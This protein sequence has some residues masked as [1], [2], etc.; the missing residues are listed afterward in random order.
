MTNRQIL[1]APKVGMILGTYGYHGSLAVLLADR[2]ANGH[3]FK[4]ERVVRLPRRFVNTP[5]KRW[6]V[7]HNYGPVSPLTTG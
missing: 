4:G 3:A 5:F 7:A 1:A 2:V 6:Q